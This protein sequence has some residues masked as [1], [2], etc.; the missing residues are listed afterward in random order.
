MRRWLVLILV[1]WAGQ[2]LAEPVFPTGLRIGLEPPADARV[3]TQ[4][5]GF[6]DPER[7]VKI[8]MLD[9]PAGAYERLA[10][11]AYAPN[12]P[13]MTDVTREAF[14]FASGIG[15]LVRGR[16]EHEGVAVTKWYLLA[17]AVAGPVQNLTVLINVEVPDAASAVYTDAVVRKALASVTFRPAPIQEQLS[18]MPFKLG[19]LAGFRVLQVLPAG[20]VI[21]IDGPGED[22]NKQPYVIVSIGGGSPSDTNDRAR[23]AR[24]VLNGAPLRELTQRSSEPMRIGGFQGHEIRATAKSLSGEPVTL[25]QWMRFGSSGYLRVVGVAHENNW[26][27]LFPRFRKVRDGISP[28]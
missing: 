8:G 9:L 7:K 19:E 16:G 6:E 27:T 13:G 10:A 26:D 14:P 28:R 22:I 23:L 15:L 11:T 1:A 18:L 17:T 5:P 4:F 25:V 2:A 24:D 20:G 21:L 3:S 12:Q